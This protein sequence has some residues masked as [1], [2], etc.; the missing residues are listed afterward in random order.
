MLAGYVLNLETKIDPRPQFANR[1]FAP[2]AFVKALTGAITS[3]KMEARSDVQSFDFR[4]L[5]L[6]EEQFPSIRTVYLIG[7]PAQLQEQFLPQVLR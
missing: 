7:D 5:V 2:E 3:G 4:T 1:T 6:V